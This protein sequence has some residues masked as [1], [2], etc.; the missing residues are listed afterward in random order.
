MLAR[1]SPRCTRAMMTC[2]KLSAEGL[3]QVSNVSPG[4]NGLI[5]DVM[6]A[7]ATG[8]VVAPSTDVTMG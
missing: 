2:R 3:G 8:G 5:A 4:Q 6:I 7:R 1:P